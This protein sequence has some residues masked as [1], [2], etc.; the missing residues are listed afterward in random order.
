MDQNYTPLDREKLSANKKSFK[1]SN[2]VLMGLI[3][4]LTVGIGAVGFLLTREKFQI[5]VPAQVE[6]TISVSPVP[7]P[8]VTE[9]VPSE[10]AAPST[11]S[12]TMAESTMSPPPPQEEQAA[13]PTPEV[14]I[15]SISTPIPV[16]C[17][18][19]S[20]DI[21]TNPCRSGLVCVQADDGSNYCTLPEF[22]S[23][24]KSNP[25]QVSCCT[26]AGEDPT[27]TEINLV[28]A[29]ATPGEAAASVPQVTEIPSAGVAT[30]GKIFA[31]ISFAVILLGLIL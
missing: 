27:P 12:G 4:F 22:E 3:L 26:P 14:T 10:T 15:A 25:S 30:F 13:T 23:A 20:C 24:C 1:I 21:A 6:P 17:G 31:V 2:K 16:A 8:A 9:V 7:S 5:R 19:K 29:S 28:V 18:T 11:D